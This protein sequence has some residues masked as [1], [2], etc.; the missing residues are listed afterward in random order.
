MNKFNL[1]IEKLSVA[2]GDPLPGR[3]AQFLMEPHTRRIELKRQKNHANAKLSS[4]LILLYPKDG[5]VYTIM[6]K[7]PVYNG[8]HSGQ[9]AFPGGR[10]EDNDLD[11]TDTALRETEEEIGIGRN[12][13]KVIGQL[14]QLYIP[15]SN[16]NVLPI[17]GYTNTLPD[18]VLDKNEV[19]STL[20]IDIK[21]L[22]DPKYICH[23]KV[24]TRN[25]LRVSVICYFIQDEIIWG[26]S[27]MIISE[28]VEIL[29]KINLRS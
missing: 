6:I 29:K 22:I 4:V 19:E 9:I 16:F 25:N 12:F 28:F 1:F 3:E 27:A 15:P 23:K 8:V 14:T 21:N 10:K 7:R 18:F 5:K 2:L 26:A 11:L 24:L 17:V 20:E 13:V